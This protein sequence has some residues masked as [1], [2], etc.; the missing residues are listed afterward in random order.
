MEASRDLWPTR[1]LRCLDR[2]ACLSLQDIGCDRQVWIG[3]KHSSPRWRSHEQRRVLLSSIPFFSQG[4]QILCDDMI[5]TDEV[6]RYVHRPM[7]LELTVLSQRV[8]PF[9]FVWGG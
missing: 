6:N 1:E 3:W 9:V 7:T 2:C 8:K 5:A 4:N